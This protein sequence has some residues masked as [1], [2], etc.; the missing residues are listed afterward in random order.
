M[1]ELEIWFRIGYMINLTHLI[2]VQEF[3]EFIK[4]ALEN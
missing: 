2:L 4:F 1:R 3:E